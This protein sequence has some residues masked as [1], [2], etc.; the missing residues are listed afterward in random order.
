[1]RPHFLLNVFHG[2][3]CL[4]HA[5]LGKFDLFIIDGSVNFFHRIWDLHKAVNAEHHTFQILAGFAYCLDIMNGI[6][7]N[8]L[9]RG[10]HF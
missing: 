6:L 4:N 1:M 9:G 7:E 5:E 8:I 3:G 2:I 10:G